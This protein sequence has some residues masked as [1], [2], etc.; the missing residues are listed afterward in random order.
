MIIPIY[1]I[2]LTPFPTPTRRIPTF[3][4]SS[5]VD[6]HHTLQIENGALWSLWPSWRSQGVRCQKGDLNQGLK[7][8]ALWLSCRTI[9]PEVKTAQ[10]ERLCLVAQ[11]S[12]AP[13]GKSLWGAE[14]SGFWDGH[15]NCPLLFSSYICHQK[16]A[17]IWNKRQKKMPYKFKWLMNFSP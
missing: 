3:I 12:R 16:L 7:W 1:W 5:V 10:R 6:S 11:A 14:S 2:P 13:R 4:K 9:F 8:M 17:F 15:L